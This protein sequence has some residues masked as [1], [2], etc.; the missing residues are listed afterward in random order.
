M[1]NTN[2]IW[3]NHEVRNAA[4]S[5]IHALRALADR[6]ILDRDS[7]NQIWMLVRHDI[8][9]DVIQLLSTLDNKADNEWIL[10]HPKIIAIF[11]GKNH[12]LKSDIVEFLTQNNLISIGQR[13]I[14]NFSLGKSSDDFEKISMIF[15]K[16]DHEIPDDALKFI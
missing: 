15:C 14:L 9:H 11:S 13:N 8:S 7:V 2:E 4:L 3:Q 6:N 10:N 1:T 5:S 12:E 16:N